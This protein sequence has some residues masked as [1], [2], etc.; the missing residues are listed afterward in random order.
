MTRPKEVGDEEKLAVALKEGL[1]TYAGEPEVEIVLQKVWTYMPRF[2]GN[3][4]VEECP[5]KIL[6]LQGQ[7]NTF[8]IG[9]SVCFESAL[10]QVTYNIMLGRKITGIT[11]GKA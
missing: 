8:Y 9:S 1:K 11:A 4:L 6:S 3:G 2:Q 10:D 7:R 5:W